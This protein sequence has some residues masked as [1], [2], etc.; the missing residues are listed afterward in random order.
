MASPVLVDSRKKLSAL[1]TRARALL[2]CWQP[3]CEPASAG[4]TLV[5]DLVLRFQPVGLGCVV[6]SCNS[7]GSSATQTRGRGIETS[8]LVALGA[9]METGRQGDHGQGGSLTVGCREGWGGGAVEEASRAWEMGRSLRAL[10]VEG[11]IR[12]TS[13]GDRE[14]RAR[15]KASRRIAHV[16]AVAQGYQQGLPFLPS[17]SPPPSPISCPSPLPAPP[18]HMWELWPKGTSRASC[19]LPSSPCL[20]RASATLHYLQS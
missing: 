8:H 14:S 6:C 5:P 18:L 1:Q 16:G 9:G 2:C 11:H 7:P 10:G 17:P 20:L 13:C 15:C 19:S 12:G 4:P 3:C